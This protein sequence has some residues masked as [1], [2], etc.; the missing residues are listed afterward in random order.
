MCTD[1][2]AR[3]MDNW[4]LLEFRTEP[5]LPT[6]LIP[7]YSGAWELKISRQEP[8]SPSRPTAYSVLSHCPSPALTTTRRTSPAL[9]QRLNATTLLTRSVW[10]IWPEGERSAE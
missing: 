1:Q 9:F 4:P 8:E 7:P 6:V 10:V 5:G 3:L 2:L